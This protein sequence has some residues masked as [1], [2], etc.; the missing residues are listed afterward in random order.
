MSCQL[1]SYE[2]APD[3]IK[4]LD[5]S[6]AFFLIWEPGSFDDC[7]GITPMDEIRIKMRRNMAIN[8]M[9]HPELVEGKKVAIGQRIDPL[10]ARL[11]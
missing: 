8:F 3:K 4:V 5:K 11:V 7:Y 9:D 2:D 1:V 10:L 6:A